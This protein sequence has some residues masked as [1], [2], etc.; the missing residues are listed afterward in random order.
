METTDHFDAS[1]WRSCRDT[2]PTCALHG[3]STR[4]CANMARPPA[5]TVTGNH[6]PPAPC[7]STRRL[8]KQWWRFVS[9]PLTYQHATGTRLSRRMHLTSHKFSSTRLYGMPGCSS[10][11]AVPIGFASRRSARPSSASLPPCLCRTS[12]LWVRCGCRPSSRRAGP[13]FALQCISDQKRMTP[14]SIQMHLRASI[15]CTS[16]GTPLQ[17]TCTCCSGSVQMPPRLGR[18]AAAAS[19]APYARQ[20]RRRPAPQRAERPQ[21]PPRGK[22]PRATSAI[23]AAKYNDAGRDAVST[24]GQ[25]SGCRMVLCRTVSYRTSRRGRLSKRSR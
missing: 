25:L 24:V 12:Y 1:S 21:V 22:L 3:T 2:C 20:L 15:R 17:D 11:S 13:V 14:S 7:T 6:G 23:T 9:Q 19:S 16:Q 10:I 4:S 8:K 18:G 5:S